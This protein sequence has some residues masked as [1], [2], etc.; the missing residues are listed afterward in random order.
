MTC[1]PL[2]FNVLRGEAQDI[3]QSPYGSVGHLFTGGGVEA[4]W[5]AKHGEPIDPGWF[6]QNHVDLILVVQGELRFEFE[7]ADLPARVLGPGDFMILPGNT[8]C[9]AYRWPRERSEATIFVA[10]Y[11]REDRSAN[12]LA[13]YGRHNASG[14]A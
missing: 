11:P 10:V 14:P 4:V 9:R 8:R 6:S 1:E 13:G 5:V 2:V 3:H 7:R 12:G